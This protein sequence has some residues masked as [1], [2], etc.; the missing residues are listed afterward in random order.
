LV[1]FIGIISEDAFS[2]AYDRGQN[3]R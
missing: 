3:V 1:L 2:I